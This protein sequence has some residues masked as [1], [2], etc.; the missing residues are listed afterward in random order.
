MKIQ[1]IWFYSFPFNRVS[2]LGYQGQYQCGMATI[3]EQPKT[4]F[5]RVAGGMSATQ[6]AHPWAASIRLK[7]TSQTTFH[8][9]GA[10]VLSE[11]YILTAGHCMEQYPRNVL[12]VR[13]G[14]WDMEVSI[15]I[16]IHT[17]MLVILEIL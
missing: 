11:F 7:G 17:R 2:P 15:L 9:C 10:V 8:H 1:Y 4:P 3:Q 14:D 5:R 12:R 6:G 13:V 16:I